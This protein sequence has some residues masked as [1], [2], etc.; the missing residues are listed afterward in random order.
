MSQAR[1]HMS[2][3]EQKGRGDW[4]LKNQERV[5]GDEVRE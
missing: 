1:Q 4:S 3:L 2:H 5:V